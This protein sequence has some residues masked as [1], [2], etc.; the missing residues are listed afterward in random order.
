[1]SRVKNTA[2][3]KILLRSDTLRRGQ[4]P[5][6][7]AY[8]VLIACSPTASCLADYSEA[9]TNNNYTKLWHGQFK[10]ALHIQ[11]ALLLKLVSLHM[12]VCMEHT[13]TFLGSRCTATDMK[14][15]EC[16]F[17]KQVSGSKNPFHVFLL[18]WNGTH[19]LLVFAARW[20]EL[21]VPARIC[22]GN[23]N[24]GAQKWK[25]VRFPALQPGHAMNYRSGAS[26]K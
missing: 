20:W 11:D 2:V 14:Q 26:E 17:A 21:R 24:V 5:A 7:A 3:I 9:S 1:M 12:R 23:L 13:D 6:T 22:L 8:Y 19:D 16:S 10:S 18:A 25:L 4:H 15:L